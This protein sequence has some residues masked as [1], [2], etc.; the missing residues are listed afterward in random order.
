MVSYSYQSQSSLVILSTIF[1][2][3]LS[4]VYIKLYIVFYLVHL[5]CSLYGIFCMQLALLLCRFKSKFL[6]LYMFAA[7]VVHVC[8]LCKYVVHDLCLSKYL[9][10]PERFISRGSLERLSPSSVYCSITTK[11]DW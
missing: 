8:R 10:S 1:T 2:C 3:S 9:Y 6:L 5:D 4:V 7:Y 11:L